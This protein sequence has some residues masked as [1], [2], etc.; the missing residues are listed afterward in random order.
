[1]DLDE[2]FD[3][4]PIPEDMPADVAKMFFEETRRAVNRGESLDSLLG[5]L[6][7]SG[8]PRPSRRKGR[9]K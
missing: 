7:G 6:F 5:R 2:I 8:T 9:R 1:M 4:M 3:E